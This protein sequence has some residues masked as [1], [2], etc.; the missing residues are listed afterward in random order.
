MDF[1]LFLAQT[2]L[3]NL[4]TNNLGSYDSYKLMIKKRLILEKNGLGYV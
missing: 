3:D 1:R 4:R 2:Q